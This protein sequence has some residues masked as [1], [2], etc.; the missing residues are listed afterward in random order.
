MNFILSSRIHPAPQLS[1]GTRTKKTLK[2]LKEEPV[3]APICTV[4]FHE[5]G[6]R[7]RSMFI[8][9]HEIE[10]QNSVDFMFYG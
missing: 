10:K 7:G 5:L 4:H 8:F 9:L 3:G 6:W 2:D 1:S